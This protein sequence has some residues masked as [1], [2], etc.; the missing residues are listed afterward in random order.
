MRS[1]SRLDDRLIAR[2]W[3]SVDRPS[4]AALAAMLTIGGVLIF[5][6]GPT[7]AA[8]MNINNEFHFAFRQ[9]LFLGPSI[10]LLFIAS[11]LPPLQARRVGVI[12]F[13]L[14]LALM[15]YALVFGSVINGARRWIDLGSFLLQP[16]EFAKTGFVISAAWMMA[17]GA[18]DPKFPGGTFA[19]CLYV[20]FASLLMMQPDF[21]QWALIT[22]V[23]AVMFFVAGWSWIW[24]I[25]LAVAG[26]AALAAGYFFSPHVA[27][28]IDGFLQPENGG[29]YQ[30]DRALET[31]N[32]GGVFGRFWRDDVEPVKRLLPD[33]HTDFIFAVAGEEF[34]FVLCV[35]II[36]LFAFFVIRNL[37]IAAGLRSLFAQ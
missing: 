24:V 13:G 4:I 33:A 3:F 25:A 7:A 32:N 6:A 19:L 21:G 34:G 20:V 12:L 37:V 26:C 29:N 22:A 31:L 35:L 8:R 11:L 18:R 17:E 14:M 28:R 2:W 5:A 30:V 15:A 1:V 10:A 23:W 9:L 27:R 16:S 36:G